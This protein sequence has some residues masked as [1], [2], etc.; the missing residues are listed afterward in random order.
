L[1][2]GLPVELWV[3]LTPLQIRYAHYTNPHER[4]RFAPQWTGNLYWKKFDGN[5]RKMGSIGPGSLRRDDYAGCVY[6]SICDA[7]LLFHSGRFTMVC[8]DAFTNR[9]RA[10]NPLVPVCDE[11]KTLYKMGESQCHCYADVRN[12]HVEGM[13]TRQVLR[14]DDKLVANNP[15][16]ARHPHPKR[17]HAFTTCTSNTWRPLPRKTGSNL[18]QLAKL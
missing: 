16:E 14:T 11:E 9:P 13:P 5:C 18:C 2:H 15:W 3:S 4:Q 7:C 17:L 6:A 10:V 8:L 12:I 1:V